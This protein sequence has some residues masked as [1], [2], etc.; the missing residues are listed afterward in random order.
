MRKHCT[1][2]VVEERVFYCEL[3]S[4]WQRN[5]L[6]L[7]WRREWNSQ[8][9]VEL[10]LY[11]LRY[12]LTWS[13][14]DLL[15]WRTPCAKEPSGS[16]LESIPD[17]PATLLPCRSGRQWHRQTA[18]CD[19]RRKGRRPGRRRLLPSLYRRPGKTSLSVCRSRSQ[20][21]Q[22]HAPSTPAHD[23]RRRDRPRN[24][25][26]SARPKAEENPP[27]DAFER[28]AF[29]QPSSDLMAQFIGRRSSSAE[30]SLLVARR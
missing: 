19:G 12:R 29:G 15:F 9:C 23:C 13:T 8:P 20:A 28:F 7:L 14:F 5:L 18:A 25:R 6:I 27:S 26:T 21:G 16:C 3:L 11:L 2:S 17:R 24:G 10:G 22:D 30:A 1:Y 4:D